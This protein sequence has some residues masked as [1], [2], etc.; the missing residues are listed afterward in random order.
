MGKLRTLLGIDTVRVVLEGALFRVVNFC[1]FKR[2][3]RGFTFSPSREEKQEGLYWPRL[4]FYPSNNFNAVPRLEIE[5]S[6]P[7]MAFGNNVQEL[8]LDDKALLLAELCDRLKSINIDTTPENLLHGALN[9][10]DFGKN[11]L[12]CDPG[13]SLDELRKVL[14]SKRRVIGQ[15]DYI[16][17]GRGLRFR[18]ASSDI[19]FYDKLKDP[20]LSEKLRL[21]SDYYCQ[22]SLLQELYDQG[23]SLLR[24]ECRFIKRR[25]VKQIFKRFGITNPIFEDVFIPGIGQKIITEEWNMILKN[26]IPSIQRKESLL[27]QIVH[28]LK[29]NRGGSLDSLLSAQLLQILLQ[30]HSL[31]EIKNI[32]SRY[33]SPER[34]RYFFKKQR[35]ILPSNLTNITIFD[36]I[37]NQ[38]NSWQPVRLP[39]TPVSKN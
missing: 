22:R 4:A 15:T 30:E 5:L 27:Q 12:G 29:E 39:L 24:M 13:I 25:D 34:I 35:S 38:I 18:N 37:T 1:R 14:S 8:T 6:L 19:S 10:V 2:M 23:T 9:R 3:P 28:L 17:G 16:N 20:D 36:S 33:F 7:K 26:Y 21:D 32:F 11:I 31:D